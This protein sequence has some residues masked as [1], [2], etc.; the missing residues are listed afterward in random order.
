MPFIATWPGII[1][2]GTSSN[3]NGCFWDLFPTF[4]Q[5]AGLQPSAGIDGISILPAL[6]QHQQ[7]QHDYLYWEF[8]EEGGKQA[9]RW[10]KW[11]G[12]KLKVSLL[13]HPVMELYNLEA[14]NSEQHNIAAQHPD[15]VEKI[16]RIM[17][18][19]HQSNKDWPLL[20]SEMPH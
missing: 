4:Q 13:D 8:Q 10:G 20:K 1:K 9:V 5:V 12:I 3:F 2:A 19:A 18:M 15:V 11:K 7:Q 17:R 16:D 6:K 14:D